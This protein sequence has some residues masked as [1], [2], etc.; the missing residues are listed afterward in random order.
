MSNMQI[1][2]CKLTLR[3]AEG[4]YIDIQTA[5]YGNGVLNNEEVRRVS[6][7][8]EVRQLC[9]YSGACYFFPH[10][11]FPNRI[12]G[13]DNY[14]SV[15]FRCI[16][17][18]DIC[19]KHNCGP[20]SHCVPGVTPLR[21]ACDIGYTLR[22]G[23]CSPLFGNI[24][25]YRVRRSP[26]MA[27]PSVRYPRD[28]SEPVPIS[29]I[30]SEDEY[31]S[32]QNY[33]SGESTLISL[34]NDMD[35]DGSYKDDENTHRKSIGWYDGYEPLRS[36]EELANKRVMAN[37]IGNGSVPSNA[38]SEG[39]YPQTNMHHKGIGNGG[40][41]P[42]KH[43]TA[44]PNDTLNQMVDTHPTGNA[45]RVLNTASNGGADQRLPPNTRRYIPNNLLMN[46]E[47]SSIQ[48][49]N[50]EAPANSTSSE[51]TT[52]RKHDVVNEPGILHTHDRNHV[53]PTTGE[54]NRRHS[55]IPLEHAEPS[56]IQP[57]N[58]E[59]PANSTSSEETTMRKHD[60]V[61]EPGILHTHDGNHGTG[62]NSHHSVTISSHPRRYSQ[63]D[64]RS[65]DLMDEYENDD[66]HQ[67]T[68]HV[69]NYI[70]GGNTDNVGESVQHQGPLL[71]IATK[72]SDKL[73]SVSSIS[74][75][76]QI[77]HR[78][79]AN[80]HTSDDDSI[81]AEAGEHGHISFN[82]SVPSTTR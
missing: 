43:Y 62:Q 41:N 73:K 71:H 58:Q 55:A 38:K 61:N 49:N 10:Q 47:P 70:R 9:Q 13:D 59:A 26:L 66:A 16:Q 60:V 78:M 75:D 74:H 3:C 51:E 29:S 35:D 77:Q 48:P 19:Y 81:S 46:A 20:N 42:H 82:C 28:S 14:A 1:S 40:Y 72:S 11:Q 67:K 34:Q 6:V 23:I 53:V 44:T 18:N 8:N 56:S 30:P 33:N 21:C 68:L 12:Q 65:T 52:M 57:N 50:Q 63:A 37:A 36:S 64:G 17:E 54:H 79:S 2:P 24:K 22:H 25:I 15:N 45:D 27:F 76:E 5:Y 69:V 80:S 39:A 32:D 31:D 7:T 4:W